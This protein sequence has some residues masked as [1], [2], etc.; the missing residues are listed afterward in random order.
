MG[1]GSCFSVR[2]RPADEVTATIFCQIAR[3]E[4][5][6]L[7]DIKHT[8]TFSI[9]GTLFASIASGSVIL[10]HMHSMPFQRHPVHRTLS[11]AR[12]LKSRSSHHSENPRS[13]HLIAKWRGSVKSRGR[14]PGITLLFPQAHALRIPLATSSTGGSSARPDR[15]GAGSSRAGKIGDIP[16]LRQPSFENAQSKPSSRARGN[17]HFGGSSRSLALAVR[18]WRLKHSLAPH[19]EPTSIPFA[20]AVAGDSSPAI[21]VARCKSR[22]FSPDPTAG[23]LFVRYANPVVPST[24]A[25]AICMTKVIAFWPAPHC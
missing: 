1:P 13:R 7:L 4:Q 24:V 25:A 11:A 14:L 8:I 21:I 20:C 6:L 2:C 17:K 18:R 19:R 3:A 5:P 9:F 12:L 16:Y 10:Y 23:R 22:I 15:H